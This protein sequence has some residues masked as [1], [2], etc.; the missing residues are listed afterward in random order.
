METGHNT[1]IT[2]FLEEKCEE[3]EFLTLPNMF[4]FNYFYVKLCN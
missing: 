3:K 4:L 2:P 1:W